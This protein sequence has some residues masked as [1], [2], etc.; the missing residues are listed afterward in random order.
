MRLAWA[1]VG[2]RQLRRAPA[3]L[4]AYQEQAEEPH[5]AQVVLQ[6]EDHEAVEEDR[7]GRGALSPQLDLEDGLDRE[8]AVGH[9]H[10]WLGRRVHVA[11]S[12]S[13]RQP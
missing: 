13:A 4:G 11:R 2:A 1:H 9:Q 7:A 5:A 8:E 6:R 12:S 3:V 10:Q